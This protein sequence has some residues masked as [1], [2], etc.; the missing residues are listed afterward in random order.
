M[1]AVTPRSSLLASFTALDSE[2]GEESRPVLVG[3]APSES[4]E[5]LPASLLS[6]HPLA[7]NAPEYQIT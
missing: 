1:Q 5:S 7:R 2:V 4:E 3:G 6:R